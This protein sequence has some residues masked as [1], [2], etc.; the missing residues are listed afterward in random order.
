MLVVKLQD[1]LEEMGGI[2]LILHELR[3]YIVNDDDL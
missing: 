2:L 1:W 3:S